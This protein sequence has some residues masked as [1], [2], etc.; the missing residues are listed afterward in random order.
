MCALYLVLPSYSHG[1]CLAVLPPVSSSL[2]IWCVLVSFSTCL[3]SHAPSCLCFSLFCVF[4]RSFIV[5]DSLF[6]TCSY[7][8][9][10]SLTLLFEIKS[11]LY[12]A[13]ILG[14]SPS[15]QLA[16]LDKKQKQKSLYNAKQLESQYLL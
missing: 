2:V 5:L 4:C 1:L 14:P 15:C 10:A 9:T 7:F 6:V 12:C 11:C 3:L 13:C 8:V 16:I